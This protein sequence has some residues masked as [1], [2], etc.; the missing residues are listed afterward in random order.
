MFSK[1][2]SFSVIA[3]GVIFFAVFGIFANKQYEKY[4]EKRNKLTLDLDE[5]E[6]VQSSLQT[7]CDGIWPEQNF[8][9]KFVKPIYQAY[10]KDMPSSTM[11]YENFHSVAFTEVE[12][13][14]DGELVRCQATVI[15]LLHDINKGNTKFLMY[16]K[17]SPNMNNFSF[18]IEK[19]KTY[20]NVFESALASLNRKQF[21]ALY[22]MAQEK[23]K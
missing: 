4:Q 14:E 9:N 21:V 2:T 8:A 5:V 17:Y 6:V 11:D 3:V 13:I 1:Q 12:V 18:N 16:I 19:E 22:K 15:L 10:K 7:T 20:S 23:I